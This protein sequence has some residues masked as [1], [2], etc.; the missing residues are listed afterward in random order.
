MANEIDARFAS[1]L[2]QMSDEDVRR[3][4]EPSVQPVPLLRAIAVT[5]LEKRRQMRTDALSRPKFGLGRVAYGVVMFAAVIAAIGVW[6]SWAGY[7]G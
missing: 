2:A 6:L 4:I 5:E 3:Q 1:D 7:V